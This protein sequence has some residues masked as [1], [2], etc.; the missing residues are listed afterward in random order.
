MFKNEYDKQEDALIASVGQELPALLRPQAEVIRLPPEGSSYVDRH[1]TA[2]GLQGVQVKYDVKDVIQRKLAL[3]GYMT[4]GE[5]A[6]A[7][8]CTRTTCRLKILMRR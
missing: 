7:I 4:T 1:F 6:I 8:G 3:H 5:L 2:C